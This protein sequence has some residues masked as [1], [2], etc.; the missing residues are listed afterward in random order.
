MSIHTRPIRHNISL[1]RRSHEVW[2]RDY[3]NIIQYI[4]SNNS[5]PICSLMFLPVVVFFAVLSVSLL[6]NVSSLLV[7]SHQYSSRGSLA[8]SHVIIHKFPTWLP[9][10]SSTWVP[11]PTVHSVQRLPQINE[12]ATFYPYGLAGY[13]FRSIARCEDY[14][15]E[16]NLEH[17]LPR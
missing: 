9:G 7:A 16:D 10:N 3:Y 13:R 1:V 5:Q 12:D 11:S 6:P 8:R 17:E 4:I 14:Y 15:Q 2:G